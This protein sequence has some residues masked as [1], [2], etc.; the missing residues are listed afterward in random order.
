VTRAKNKSR[1]TSLANQKFYINQAPPKEQWNSF[2]AE[3][4]QLA[5]HQ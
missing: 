5:K 1:A 3:M 2:F 4:Q